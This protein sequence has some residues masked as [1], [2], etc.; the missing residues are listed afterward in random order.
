M[1]S[2]TE[3]PTVCFFHF[4]LYLLELSRSVHG[5]SLHSDSWLSIHVHW[6][7]H[8]KIL[9]SSAC[10]LAKNI[11][12]WSQPLTHGWIVG[13]FPWHNYSDTAVRSFRWCSLTNISSENCSSFCWPSPFFF[14]FP[15]FCFS[16]WVQVFFNQIFKGVKFYLPSVS[17]ILKSLARWQGKWICTPPTSMIQIPPVAQYIALLYHH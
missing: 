15:L 16:L 10:G 2:K 1:Q 3:N 9:Q 5:F 7:Y 11:F 8:P 6:A 12:S 14:F 13:Q 17:K 4:F